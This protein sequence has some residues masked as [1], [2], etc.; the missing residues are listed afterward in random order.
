MLVVLPDEIKQKDYENFLE[1]EELAQDGQV[2]LKGIF[3]KN[4]YLVGT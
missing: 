3:K 1:Q 4:I 2:H